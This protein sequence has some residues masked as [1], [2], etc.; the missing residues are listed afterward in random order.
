MSRVLLKIRLLPR[1][2]SG[3]MSVELAVLMP[4]IVVVAL[5]AYNLLRFVCACAMFDRVAQD[6][7]LMHGVSPSGTQ[8]SVV[9]VDQVR[10]SIC[11]ALKD[12]PSCSVEVSAERVGGTGRGSLLSLSPSL[13]RFDCELRYKPW[14]S[15][16]VMAGV[17]YDAPV[18]LRHA[19]TLVVDRY[20]PGVV[21]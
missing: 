15:A 14:P 9:A 13:T 19:R 10:S 21:M 7:V 18:F 2:E 3:Q 4:V 6:A 8:T 12:D 11:D 16:F 1:E 5:V 20:R 17:R